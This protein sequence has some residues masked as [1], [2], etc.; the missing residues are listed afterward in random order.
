MIDQQINSSILQQPYELSIKK[1]TTDFTETMDNKAVS[2]IFI[3]QVYNCQLQFTET[4]FTAIF[5]TKFE[6]Y[7]VIFFIFVFF[8]VMNIF[9]NKIPYL[10]KRQLNYLFVL[11]N[12]LNQINVLLELHRHLLKLHLLK[13]MNMVYHG[14]DLNQMNILS[15]GQLHHHHHRPHFHYQ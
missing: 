15:L 8:I 14:I 9:F 3:K 12:V 10:L 2:C 7:D 6:N 13:I 11:K 4:N 5:Y 1:L